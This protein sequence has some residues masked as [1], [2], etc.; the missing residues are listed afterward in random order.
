MPTY[1]VET[2]D[3]QVY[4]IE[5]PAGG[6][7]QD[8]VAQLQ[9][10]LAPQSAP[11]RPERYQ[12]EGYGSVALRAIVD[13]LKKPEDKLATLQQYYPDAEATDDGNFRYTDNGKQM[14]Y[15]EPGLDKGDVGGFAREIAMGAGAALSGAAALAAG[16]VGWPLAMT[17][18]GAGGAGSGALYD[19]LTGAFTDK[20][21]TRGTGER[22]ADAALDVGFNATGANVGKTAARAAKEAARRE[23]QASAKRLNTKLPTSIATDSKMIGRLENSL[24]S[25]TTGGPTILSGRGAVDDALASKYGFMAKDSMG[26]PDAMGTAIANDL[27]NAVK[28]GKRKSG[29]NYAKVEDTFRAA[30]NTIDSPVS[31]NSLDDLVRSVQS[32]QAAYGPQADL[33]AGAPYKELLKRS[34]G[35]QKSPFTWDALKKYRTQT[36][37]AMSDSPLFTKKA[38]STELKSIYANASKDMNKAARELGGDA[39][40]AAQKKANKFHKK[41]S[42][43]FEKLESV[44]GIPRGKSALGLE[45]RA[46]AIFNKARSVFYKNPKHLKKI[47]KVMEPE[48]KKAFL[49]QMIEDMGRAKPGVQGATAEGFSGAT[50]TTNLAKL[51]RDAPEVFDEFSQLQLRDIED[52]NRIALATKDLRRGGNPS[53]TGKAVAPWL[54]SG[55]GM[56]AGAAGGPAGMAVGAAAANLAPALLAKASQSGAAQS[57]LMGLGNNAG[58]L[59]VTGRLAAGNLGSGLLDRPID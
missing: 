48:Q 32:K 38:D 19:L 45:D 2:P 40:A 47:L 46:V 50:F 16:P 3:G 30:G 8:A 44:L 39:G 29:R 1:E 13:P 53:G 51:K 15:N 7:E 10:M 49:S 27:G 58:L 41:M 17:A 56:G 42:D 54:L 5:T 21:D 25:T 6:T 52:L 22:V 9:Q 43:K 35:A 34:E 24:E 26:S 23:L 59:G 20:I 4:E 55:L 31:I 18:A 28:A 33:A 12:P 57:L 11:K 14:L 36:G 37:K